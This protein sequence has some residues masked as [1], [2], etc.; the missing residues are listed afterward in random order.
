[1]QTNFNSVQLADPTIARADAILRRCVHCGLCTA[2]CPTYVLTGDERDSPRGRI[3]FMKQMFEEREVTPSMTYHI[4]RCLSCFSCMTTCP[5]GVDYMHLV[6]L[7]RTRIEAK[8][9]RTPRT[10]TLRW[11]V[12]K[13]LP[14]PRRF[15]LALT[16]GWLARPF[17]NLIAA[18]RVRAVRRRA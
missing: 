16:L 3:Y 11:I 14:N 18:R 4:D 1:M 12:S 2:T 9:H 10:R 6:D 17:R 5:S 8:G 15:R 7:A 13:V